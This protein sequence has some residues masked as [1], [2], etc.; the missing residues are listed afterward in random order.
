MEF[1][2]KIKSI[3]DENS[4]KKVGIFIDMDGVIAD[5]DVYGYQDIHDN[6]NNVFFD[7][8]P[9]N[10]TINI[11]K[12][13]VDIDNLEFYIV[14]ACIYENQAIDKSL[15]LDKYLPFI[16]KENRHFLIKKV[17]NYDRVSKPSM[18]V[19]VIL[20]IMRKE[21]LCLVVYVDD[22]HLMLR[23]A[24]IDLGDKVICYHIS[25]LLD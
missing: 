2:N 5:Y 25:S 4:D 15:W 13:L 16:K 23:Q 17:V 19:K 14:S 11:L 21:G 1:V 18:K 12:G 6:V 22:E 20:D 8:R 9:I 24:Q 7:K 10:T 3:C